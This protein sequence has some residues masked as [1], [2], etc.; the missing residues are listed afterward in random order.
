LDAAEGSGEGVVEES[1]LVGVEGVEVVG[2][3]TISA[4]LGFGGEQRSGVILRSVVE[5][6][7]RHPKSTGSG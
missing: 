4:R 6:E 3:R 2:G 5:G 7:P 1:F